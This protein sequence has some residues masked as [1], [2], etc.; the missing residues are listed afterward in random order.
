M[1]DFSGDR[2][3]GLKVIG[4]AAF[5]LVSPA[6][7][8]SSTPCTAANAGNPFTA[9]SI[10]DYQFTPTYFAVSRGSTLTF[11][12]DGPSVHTATFT[13]GPETFDSGDLNPGQTSMHAFGST[14]GVV[15]LHCKIHPFM[16]ATAIVQ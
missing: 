8:T 7:C 2:R 14:A 6:G 3:L 9:V 16:T 15:D 13:S 11:T 4:V 1:F 5:L 12:N 10:S